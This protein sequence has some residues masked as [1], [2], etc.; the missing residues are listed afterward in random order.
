[1]GAT[2]TQL[3]EE[4]LLW[5]AYRDAYRQFAGEAV[6]LAKIRAQSS[7]NAAEAEKA[8]LRLEEAHISYNDARDLLAASRMPAAFWKAFWAIPPAARQDD[9]R[10]KGMAELLWELAGKPEGTAED[11]WYRAERVVR[12]SGQEICVAS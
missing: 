8:L 10:V 6:R 4:Q 7:Y 1:M 9:R 12:Q 5:H 11:D 2:L 3:S